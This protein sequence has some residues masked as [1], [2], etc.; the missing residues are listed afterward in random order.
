M[1][2]E[3]QRDGAVV[4]SAE[5]RR[6]SEEIPSDNATRVA[7]F[8]AMHQARKEGRSALT[9]EE[10]HE[11]VLPRL[12]VLVPREL[13][14]AGESAYLQ[15]KLRVCLDAGLLVT[16]GKHG[17]LLALTGYAPR[18][19]FPNNE[20]RDYT[21]GLEPARERLDADNARLRDAHFDVRDHVTSTAAD[22]ERFG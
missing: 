10:L 18:V 2:R 13:H 14:L 12:H 9:V 8:D 15:D 1:V 17:E 6:D 5:A 4:S 22:P 19:R 20:I 21:P 11:R 3:Q 7:I 16:T